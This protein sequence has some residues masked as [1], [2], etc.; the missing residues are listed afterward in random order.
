MG[1]KMAVLIS[2]ISSGFRL[3]ISYELTIIKNARKSSPHLSTSLLES[4]SSGFWSGLNYEKETEISDWED[5]PPQYPNS[6]AS[7]DFC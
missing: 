7:L 2:G 5:C 6:I 4:L 3:F 1:L